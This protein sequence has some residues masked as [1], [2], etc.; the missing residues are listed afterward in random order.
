MIENLRRE[1]SAAERKAFIETMNEFYRA[2]KTGGI[3]LT[4]IPCYPSFA[5]FIDP[6]HVNF[7]T[8]GTYKYFS[9]NNFA[10]SLGYGFSGE[11]KTLSAGWYPW[12]GSWILDS[13]VSGLSLIHI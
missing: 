7:I 11:F 13:T 6:T 9:D 5:T 1:S 12:A 8:L 10:K 4:V 2:L 3:L